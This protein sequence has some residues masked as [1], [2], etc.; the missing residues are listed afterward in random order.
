MIIHLSNS[1]AATFLYLA[2]LC[3][4]AAT[5][6]IVSP[7]LLSAQTRADVLT[8]QEK[9]I[10]D[11]IKGLRQLPDDVRARTTKEFALSIRQLPL[12]PNKLRLAKALANLSTEGDFGHDTLQEVATTLADGLRNPPV[13]HNKREQADLDDSYGW[14]AQLVRYEHVQASLDAP[15]FAAA[16]AKLETDDEHRRHA[17]FTLTDLHG[18]TWNLKSL[19]G[20]V[21]LLNF[22]ATWC[23]PC[24]KEMPD[25]DALYQR[26]KDQG[27]IILAISDEPPAK[28]TPFITQR[29][30]SYPILLD[31]KRKV[32]D[33]FQVFGIPKSFVY[34]RDGKLVAQ[35]IDMRTQKQ[36][37]EMLGQAGLQ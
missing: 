21:V 20:K 4:A 10:A 31:P 14:L 11:Q 22:W 23:P 28:V 16:L 5:V 3:L 9:T 13:A 36:F 8:P 2:S 7:R 15:Q 32:N 18:R 26:F 27:L 25:L 12:T 29:N 33:E 34:D 1:R 6:F 37:L 19:H 30:I 24:R 17:D 35:S